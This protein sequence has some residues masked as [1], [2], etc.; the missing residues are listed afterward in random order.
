MN[1][2]SF[3]IVDYENISNWKL[4]ENKANTKLIQTQTNPTCS[5]L[6]EPISNVTL[7]KLV[8]SRMDYTVD[9]TE[10]SV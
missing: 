10:K 9:E 7:K 4:G 3:H 1:I 2:K 5:E 6:V 8:V